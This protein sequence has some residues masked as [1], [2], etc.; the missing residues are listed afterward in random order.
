[1]P[2]KTQ[3]NGAALGVRTGLGAQRSWTKE[4]R[5]HEKYCV[6]TSEVGEVS[7]ESTPAAVPMVIA[8]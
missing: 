8:S 4:R 3:K 6:R 7:L 2:W 1:M 5:Y